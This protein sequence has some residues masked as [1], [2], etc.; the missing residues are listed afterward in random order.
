VKQTKEEL[1]RKK[2]EYYQRTKEARC[3]Y[4]RKYDDEARAMYKIVAG[5]E[6][7]ETGA[8]ALRLGC[9]IRRMMKE[10]LNHGK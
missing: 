10:E 4:R 7:T 6:A 5:D 2:R 1:R 8:R 3:E 9:T